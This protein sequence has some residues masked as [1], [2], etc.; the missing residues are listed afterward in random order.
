MKRIIITDRCP[1]QNVNVI[2]SDNALNQLE[3]A[4]MCDAAQID[5][6]HFALNLVQHY[7]G[8]FQPLATP[9]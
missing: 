7:H 6:H 2:L 8:P 5:L 9:R 3:L 4:Q 1:D